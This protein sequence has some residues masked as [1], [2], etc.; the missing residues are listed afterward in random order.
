M[1]RKSLMV[2]LSLILVL[3]GSVPLFA[4]E[5]W[6]FGKFTADYER[7]RYQITSYSTEWDWALGEDVIVESTQYQL[8]ELKKIDEENTELTLASTYTLPSENVKDELSFMGLSGLGAF[9]AGGGG[10]MSEFML[11]SWFGG[12]LELELGT[13]TQMFDGSRMRVVEK[14]TVAGVEGYYLTKSIR[15]EGE[16]GNRVD[17]LV[18]EWVIAPSV[19][20]PLY[21]K[22]Y[23]DGQVTF[24]MELVEYARN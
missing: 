24:V 23:E 22:T 12:E 4:Q 10:W 19:G 21:L 3:A 1:V 15:E 2:V 9:L 8:I 6:Q 11:L 20:W 16:A 5:Y 13:T 18:S 14:R 7:F 17:I